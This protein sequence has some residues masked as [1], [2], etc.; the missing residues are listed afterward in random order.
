MGTWTYSWRHSLPCSITNFKYIYDVTGDYW[1]AASDTHMV[2]NHSWGN[3]LSVWRIVQ[4]RVD[5]RDG[6]FQEG[7]RDEL[8]D[9]CGGAGGVRVEHGVL[10][11]VR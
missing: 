3:H 10:R 8:Q 11:R 7:I 2:H 5:E 4:G 1:C 9:A 6:R